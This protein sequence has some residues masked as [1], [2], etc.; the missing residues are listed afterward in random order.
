M[1]QFVF[2]S[3]I[4]GVT[5]P[6]AS[7]KGEL[8]SYLTSKG[9]MA[10]SLSDVIREEATCRGLDHSRDVLVAIGN[11]L[12]EEYGAVVLAER[13][14]KRVEQELIKNPSQNIVIE[15]F[16]NP[17]EVEVLRKCEG[18]VLLLVDAPIEL[19]FM[20]LA[21]RGRLGDAKSVAELAAHE[22][23][24]NSA[25]STAQQLGKVFALA[26]K[27][28]SNDCSREEFHARIEKVVSEL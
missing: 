22:S 14:L 18:F 9:F 25:V 20:R 24:E 27:M 4:L 23:R 16:R 21:E 6:I 26:D 17:A 28:I 1:E 15:S 11:E 12:R 3:M 19:R 7:G 2:S 8:V 5:G 10:W 13:I